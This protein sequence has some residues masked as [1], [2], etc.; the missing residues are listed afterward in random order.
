[1]PHGEIDKIR[2]MMLVTRGDKTQQARD[3]LSSEGD[4]IKI[5]KICY[6]PYEIPYLLEGKDKASKG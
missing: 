1:M 2:K 6:L 4:S 3:V 5:Q